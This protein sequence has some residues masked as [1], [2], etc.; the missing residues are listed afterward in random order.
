MGD[1]RDHV[2]DPRRHPAPQP[3]PGYDPRMP[4][5]SSG[6]DPR[7]RSPPRSSGGPPN[8]A[9]PQPSPHTSVNRKPREQVQDYR[10]RSSEVTI[11]KQPPIPRPDHTPGSLDH[12]ADIATAQGKLPDPRYG[13]GR[14]APGRSDPRYDNKVEQGQGQPQLRQGHELGPPRVPSREN[15]RPRMMDPSELMQTINQMSESEKKAYYKTL[16]DHVGMVTQDPSMRMP[17]QAPD[18]MTASGLIELII[19]HQINK[20]GP[21][22]G[23]PLIGS[24]QSPQA[25]T[26]AKDSPSK[27][28]SRSPSVKSLSERD[29]MEGPSGS[30][31]RASPGAVTMGEHLENM[32]N[33]EVNRA[34]TSPYQGPGPSSE[35]QHEQH[36]KRRGYPP[37][38]PEYRERPPSQPRPPSNS[39]HPG[40]STDERQ[41]LRVAQN[42]SPR[43]D[44]PPSRG[45]HEAISPPGNYYPSPAGAAGPGPGAQDQAMSRL[46][47]A[48]RSEAARVAA[49][50]AAPSR[51]IDEYVKCKITEVMRNEKPGGA[52]PSDMYKPPGAHGLPMGPP[53]K[54]PLE[55]EARGSPLDH[56]APQQE[57]PRKRYKQ[58]EGGSQ[59]GTNDMPDSPESGDMV[60]D[61]SARPDSAHSQKTNS[62]APN[63]DPSS[64]HY[65]PGFRGGGPGA[66]VPRSSPAP[67]APAHPPTSGTAPRYEPLS[68]DD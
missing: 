65:P 2:P 4:S 24:R 23:L 39:S 45:L 33:K 59:G 37:P 47:Q 64:G 30:Q 6:R 56:G 28:P 14:S 32:I 11:T 18:H 48:Q 68:D 57:S 42:T 38:Q 13:V 55:M 35:P 36:W 27:P 49:A 15:P 17:S 52:G 8:H 66:P 60:I 67:R 21:G 54:R 34:T 25:V 1:P 22:P 12:F 3:Y 58:D 26:E 31:V 5:H 44:K 29:G 62:P 51:D 19:N 46:I 63:L 16:T 53:H 50:R 41:I 20:S 43:P 61:E 10:D 40:L 7:V 9:A